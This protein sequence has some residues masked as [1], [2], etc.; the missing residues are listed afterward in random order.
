MAGYQ[1]IYA[2]QPH[3]L[4]QEFSQKLNISELLARLLINRGVRSTTEAYYYLEPK[5]SH[6]HSA[7]GFRDMAKVT[8]RIRQALSRGEHIRIQGDYDVDGTCGASLLFLFF[9]LLGMR[10]SARVPSRKLDGYG[11]S[12]RLIDQALADE[13]SLIITVDNGITAHEQ[14][15]YAQK[16]GIDVIVTDHHSFDHG[17]PEAYALIHP[18]LEDQEYPFPDLCGCAVGF[19][20][21]LGLAEALGVSSGVNQDFEA[22]L[23][24]ALALSA[25]ASICDVMPLR[26]ENRVLVHYGLKA[27]ESTRNPGL[28]ALLDLTGV[29]APITSQDIAFRIGPRI[30]AAGRMNQETVALALLTSKSFAEACE[31]G[32]RLEE[33][34]K[35]RQGTERAVT[36]EAKEIYSKDKSYADDQVIVMG[37][38]G[39]SQG[40]V[41]IVASRMVEY[42]KRPALMLAIDESGNARGS[43]RSTPAFHLYNAAKSCEEL[44][45]KFGGHAMAIGLSIEESNIPEF[46]RKINACAAEHGFFEPECDI[47]HIDA[48]VSSED[49]NLQLAHDVLKLEPFGQENPEPLLVLEDVQLSGKPKLVGKTSRHLSFYIRSQRGESHRAIAFGLGNRWEELSSLQQSLRLVFRPRISDWTGREQLELEV[50]EFMEF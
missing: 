8:A 21:T 46:R 50:K 26:G 41:G 49:L 20:L 28:R 37:A 38:Q 12:K 5:L 29:K 23:E 1:C 35:Q 10:V 39:W 16:K 22:Y 2:H 44:F 40:V 30:N 4:V 34:N 11:L 31:I 32:E 47:L 24:T 3:A 33:L 27:L 13:V 6:L 25:I 17:L 7:S 18:R 48:L 42:T 14:I 45:K 9:Q 15:S 19:K 36:K 43:G